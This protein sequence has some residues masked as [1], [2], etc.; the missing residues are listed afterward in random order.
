MNTV[1]EEFKIEVGKD[2]KRVNSRVV[3]LYSDLKVASPIRSGDFRIDWKLTRP[4]PFNWK[5]EN[6]MKYASILWWGRREMNG[7]MYGSDQWPAGGEPMLERF[8][9]DL[10][11]I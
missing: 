2:L 3:K 8:K 9:F 7:K 6:N 11:S 10:E 5:I 1:T 4:D